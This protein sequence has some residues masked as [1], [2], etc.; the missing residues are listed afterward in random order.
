MKNLFVL[1]AILII[2]GCASTASATEKAWV[3]E[4]VAMF[5]FKLGEKKSQ[6]QLE[7][8]A[9]DYALKALANKL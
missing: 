4:W 3:D 2:S 7:A 6:S 8:L 9:L 1:L 5:V